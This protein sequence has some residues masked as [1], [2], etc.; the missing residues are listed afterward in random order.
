LLRALLASVRAMHR[1]VYADLGFARV[2]AATAVSLSSG[3]SACEE[4]VAA[5]P[6]SD[7]RYFDG[8]VE[9]FEVYHSIHG[10][11]VPI[12]TL[13]TQDHTLGELRRIRDLCLESGLSLF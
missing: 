4:L 3:Y 7:R 11:S 1:R 10:V 2:A 5:I 9:A 6:P 8:L 12:E 13:T